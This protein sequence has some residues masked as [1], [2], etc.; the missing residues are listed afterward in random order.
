M[1]RVLSESELYNLARSK[2]L[3]AHQVM[4]L[5]ENAQNEVDLRLVYD[6]LQWG[7][8]RHDDVCLKSA[9]DAT[10]VRILGRLW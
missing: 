8:G 3:S 10:C 1:G 4:T 6:N 2:R 9:F 7:R 5:I